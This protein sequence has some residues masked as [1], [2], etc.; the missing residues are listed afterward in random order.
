MIEYDGTFKCDC[1]GLPIPGAMLWVEVNGSIK[2]KTED[3]SSFRWDF[4]DLFC[5][6]EH[7]DKNIKWEDMK[8]S[9]FK[10]GA[11]RRNDEGVAKVH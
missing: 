7:L 3:Y 8:I 4:C 1:C 2:T 9:S 11:K 10:A 6:K 5:M